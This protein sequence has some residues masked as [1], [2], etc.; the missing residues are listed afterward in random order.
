[1]A[2]IVKLYLDHELLAFLLLAAIGGGAKAIGRMDEVIDMVCPLPPELIETDRSQGFSLYEDHTLQTFLL[3]DFEY[4]LDYGLFSGAVVD[5]VITVAD[6]ANAHTLFPTVASHLIKS[7]SQIFSIDVDNLACDILRYFLRGS[8]SYLLRDMNS[9]SQSDLLDCIK[10]TPISPRFLAH[11]IK[12]DL[13]NYLLHRSRQ[14]PSLN[15]DKGK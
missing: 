8:S 6:V 4:I 14:N 12:D 1:M 15:L 7:L 3:T 10:N 5:I 11:G 2:P 9:S 13:D